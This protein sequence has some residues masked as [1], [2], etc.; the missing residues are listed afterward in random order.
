[1]GVVV[2]QYLE[3]Q[4]CPLLICLEWKQRLAFD[5]LPSGQ[6]SLFP[7]MWSVLLLLLCVLDAQGEQNN[8]TRGQLDTCWAVKRGRPDWQSTSTFG[9]VCVVLLLFT[10]SLYLWAWTWTFC[11]EDTTTPMKYPN[12]LKACSHWIKAGK[13]FLASEDKNWLITTK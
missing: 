9:A 11:P 6:L 5:I 12:S 3:G 8:G 7:S 10:T 1:M 4:N 13:F 2:Q